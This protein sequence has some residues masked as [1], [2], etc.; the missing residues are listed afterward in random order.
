MISTTW[1]KAPADLLGLGGFDVR[2]VYGPSLCG[3]VAE[4]AVAPIATRRGPVC[5]QPAPPCA[6]V[7]S[8]VRPSATTS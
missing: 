8:P 5:P 1:M 2:P 7:P 6:S 4:R 3:G